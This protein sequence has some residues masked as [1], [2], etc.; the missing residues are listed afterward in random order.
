VQTDWAKY[1]IGG[2]PC[3]VND[4]EINQCAGKLVVATYGRGLWEAP[5]L[6]DV[7]TE[8][9]TGSTTWN[10]NRTVA[11]DIRVKKGATLKIE[12][13]V[14]VPTV[15]G[16]GRGVRIIVED[17]AKLEV[18]NA[19]LTNAC[20]YMWQGIEAWGDA[21]ATQLP[22]LN[23]P[24][25]QSIIQLTNATIEYANNAITTWKVGDLTTTGAIIKAT[26]SKFINNT[27]S[28]EYMKYKGRTPLGNPLANIGHFTNCSFTVNNGYRRGDDFKYHVSEWAVDGVGFEGC[29]F[30]CERSFP[31][32]H[33]LNAGI[34][35]LD[36][37][38][39]VDANCGNNIPCGNI[40]RSTF[41][42]FNKA[43][44]S[45]RSQG[46]SFVHVDRTDFSD[47]AIG[48]QSEGAVYIFARGD[49]FK[50]GK[51]G[52][53]VSPDDI[54]EGIINMSNTA[55]FI[56]E[57][58][59]SPTFS[60][61]ADPV[62]IGVRVRENGA[63][64]NSIYRNIFRKD[65][66]T[67]ANKFYGNLAN[68]TNRNTAVNGIGLK[69]ICN[70]HQNNILN[71]FDIAVTDI[72]IELNQGSVSSSAGNKFSLGTIAG[73]AP[74]GSD[75]KN[76]SKSNINYFHANSPISE[77]PQNIAGLTKIL[78]TSSSACPILYDP[79]NFENGF[80][81]I[82]EEYTPYSRTHAIVASLLL[83]KDSTN[84]IAI[85]LWLSREE[86]IENLMAI[87]ET[88][89][90][91][92]DA[93]KAEEALN[94]AIAKFT[95]DEP[96]KKE[97]DYY[98]TLKR[99]QI[100]WIRSN[101]NIFAIPQSDLE[102]LR[103]IA[104][105]SQQRAGDAARGL[106]NFAYHTQYFIPPTL[107]SQLGGKGINATD[108]ADNTTKSSE[109]GVTLTAFPNPASHI[110]NFEYHTTDK[111]LNGES[112]LLVR[113]PLGQVI[114]RIKMTSDGLVTWNIEDLSSGIYYYS[115]E[116][117]EKVIIAAQQ[118]IIA[119]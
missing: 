91:V 111:T 25:K 49:K 96:T 42:G 83:E 65:L 46:L 12:G 32:D 66:T 110:V 115:L 63:N 85:R 53:T 29:A 35:T 31:F 15:I 94:E 28:V 10:R 87:V 58:T 21:T 54:H 52:V 4:M 84:L 56:T 50:V 55:L 75:F 86:N 47:N 108:R 81:T 51:T 104:E 114:K 7:A 37:S 22:K 99:M 1:G 71:G 77:I 89:L 61:A 5:L 78:A 67:N 112:E 59:F 103:N 17:G 119:R 90:Q 102:V 14:A 82:D 2:P 23:T 109:T 80:T 98:V 93:D 107:P 9:A 16:F 30:K 34:R 60:R 19:T 57:N 18:T 27:R 62:T 64:D 88:Y 97:F 92:D 38:V 20:G 43:V 68:G 11:S 106:L 41:L 113:N 39:I 3:M 48:I 44:H 76:S 118:L 79:D 117:A 36:A 105:N 24:N 40:G 74:A 70:T 73:G 72:G 13:T 6:T 116:N 33:E 69:Y 8:I 26:N 100:R 95:L 45:T 101:T